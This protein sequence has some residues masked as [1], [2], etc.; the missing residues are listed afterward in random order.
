M[1]KV[2]QVFDPLDAALVRTDE[3]EW[4]QSGDGNKFKVLRISKE[5]G[6]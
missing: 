2:E 4:I 5:T 1:A 3:E 6:A